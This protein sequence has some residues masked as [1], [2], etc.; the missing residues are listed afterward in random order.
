M[1]QV[2]AFTAPGQ[3]GADPADLHRPARRLASRPSRH[4]TVLPKGTPL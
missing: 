1:N 3:L 4:A 2:L